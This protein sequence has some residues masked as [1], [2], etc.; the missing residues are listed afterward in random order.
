[1]V[2]AQA[3]VWVRV[4]AGEAR[5]RAEEPPSRVLAEDWRWVRAR[6]EQ[7]EPHREEAPRGLLR[8]AF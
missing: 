5:R 7:A 6:A 3:M 2:L 1:M 4:R 8:P